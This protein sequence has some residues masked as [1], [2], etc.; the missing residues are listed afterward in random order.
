M[1]RIIIFLAFFALPLLSN[2][3]YTDD[4]QDAVNLEAQQLENSYN[5]SENNEDKN[6]SIGYFLE[7]YMNETFK[8]SQLTSGLAH[9]SDETKIYSDINRLDRICNELTV[10][11]DDGAVNFDK[12][13]SVGTLSKIQAYYQETLFKLHV[14]SPYLPA[15]LDKDQKK[16]SYYIEYIRRITHQIQGNIQEMVAIKQQLNQASQLPFTPQTPEQ[17]SFALENQLSSSLINMFNSEG[18]ASDSGI[19]YSAISTPANTDVFN[20]S[21]LPKNMPSVP[22]ANASPLQMMNYMPTF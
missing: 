18:A 14:L 7:V 11:L 21:S 19:P 15:L 20:Q 10:L 3:L 13:K 8:L 16:V 9:I 22:S 2:S 6:N 1:Y 17:L 4:V 5:Y 12:F